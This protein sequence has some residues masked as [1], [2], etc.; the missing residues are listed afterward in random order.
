[1]CTEK[2]KDKNVDEKEVKVTKKVDND[3]NKKQSKKKLD[4]VLGKVD[5]SRTVA[6]ERRTSVVKK[7]LK[8]KKI[9]AFNVN[10]EEQKLDRQYEKEDN[11]PVAMMVLILVS[12]FVIGGILDGQVYPHC[13]RYVCRYGGYA[14]GVLAGSA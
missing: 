3:K 6:L 12:C 4:D 14:G 5:A 11:L 2:I 1:M 8:G 7:S 10:L 13:G 9:K